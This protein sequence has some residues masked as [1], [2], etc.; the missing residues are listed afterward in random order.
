MFR[1]GNLGH[2][3]RLGLVAASAYAQSVI[4]S[5]AYDPHY[6]NVSLLLHGDGAD[7]GTVFTDNSP[8]PKTVTA[9]GNARISTDQSRFGNSSMLLP[10]GSS[11]ISAAN[12][13]D[14][15]FGTQP[16]TIEMHVRVTTFSNYLT[17]VSRRIS[18]V[19]EPYEFS[20]DGSGN[21][22][23]LLESLAKNT[24]AVI[25]TFSGIQLSLNTW[26]HIALTGDGSVLRCFRDGVLSD[27][28]YTYSGVATGSTPL[29]IGSGG[30][31]TLVGNIDDLRITKGVAR[32]TESF[33]PPAAAFPNYGQPVYV[34]HVEV[35]ASASTPLGAASAYAQSVIANVS[36]VTM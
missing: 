12:S 1:P 27:T 28:T 29:Y 23:L 10:G 22:R 16:F 8:T 17:L 19:Y 33:T 21:P 30:D 36:G 13:T 9:Y 6:A 15:D 34:Q 35:I 26:H 24:W 7:N 18:P 14:F 4:V 2:L 25:G 20:I 32:Y 3:G 5:Q 11:H 31:G